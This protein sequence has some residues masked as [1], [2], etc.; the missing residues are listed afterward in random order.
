MNISVIKLYLEQESGFP[1][2]FTAG[3]TIFFSSV[4]KVKR[5]F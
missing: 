3:G 1:Y 2:E 5:I 4:L